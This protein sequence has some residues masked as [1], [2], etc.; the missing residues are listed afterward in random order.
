MLVDATIIASASEDETDGRWVK[1]KGN[2]IPENSPVHLDSH[3][4]LDQRGLAMMPTVSSKI[5]EPDRKRSWVISAVCDSI[6]VA[7]H[8][9][10]ITC[11]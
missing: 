6:G 10:R 9:R 8:R 3:F 11:G 7:T 2:A 5:S 4:M 1:H